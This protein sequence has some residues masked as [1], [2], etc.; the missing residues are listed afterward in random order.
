MESIDLE[1]A[2]IS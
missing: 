2:S 1:R